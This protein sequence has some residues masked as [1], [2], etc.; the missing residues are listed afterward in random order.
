MTD[1]GPVPIIRPD[2]QPPHGTAPMARGIQTG[3]TCL[4]SI[5]TIIIILASITETVY[6]TVPSTGITVGRTVEIPMDA[7]E[8]AVGEIA[9][10]TANKTGQPD[11]IGRGVD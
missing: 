6:L 7:V 5:P 1:T 8:I 9:A 2:I 11:K 10:L 4:R 3:A